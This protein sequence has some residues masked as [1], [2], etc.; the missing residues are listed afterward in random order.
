M[1]RAPLLVLLALQVA[2]PSAVLGADVPGAPPG[3]PVPPGEPAAPARPAAPA[4]RWIAT[5]GWDYGFEKLVTV[6]FQDGSTDYIRANGGYVVS[7]GA[8][9][10][11]LLEG[12][13]ETRAT[14]GFKFDRIQATDGS[15]TYT[16]FPLEIVEVWDASPSPFHLGLGASFALGTKLSGTGAARDL[17][18]DLRNSA[19]LLAQ[20]EWSM[21]F[22][23]G[24]GRWLLGGRF[25]LQRLQAEGGGP[26]IDA[27]AAGLFAGLA[28]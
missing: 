9:F 8:S 6:I 27:N 7:A 14:I 21:P 1:R 25:L 13:L 20:V 2:I 16:A 4:V 23:G 28:Y 26:A 12:R 18:L 15:I 17:N 19:G 10:L 22:A 5:A 11:P 3:E 24:R